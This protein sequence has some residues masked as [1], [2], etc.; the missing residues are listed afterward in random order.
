MCDGPFLG[1]TLSEM[2]W[3]LAF[4]NL[5][6]RALEVAKSSLVNGDQI[7]C[8]SLSL[9]LDWAVGRESVRGVSVMQNQISKA[10]HDHL[11]LLCGTI[12]SNHGRF[13]AQQ[14]VAQRFKE[15]P[16]IV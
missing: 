2:S 10:C 3:P 14:S 7:K 6:G 16:L 8:P 1:F 15:W 5:A 12:S 13:F 4:V 9:L 11:A